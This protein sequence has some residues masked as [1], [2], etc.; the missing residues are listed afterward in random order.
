MLERDSLTNFWV[1]VLK[2]V[3]DGSAKGMKSRA[4]PVLSTFYDNP[5]LSMGLKSIVGVATN[6]DSDR[7]FFQSQKMI[8]TLSKIN[9]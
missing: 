6:S 2:S 7:C 4:E 3:E 1:L 8:W 5:L 9:I